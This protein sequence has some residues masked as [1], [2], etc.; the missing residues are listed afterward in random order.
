VSGNPYMDRMNAIARLRTEKLLIENQIGDEIAKAWR[1]SSNAV[2]L[3]T[4]ASNLGMLV[5]DVRQT[6]WDRGIQV[7]A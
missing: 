4:F 3:D 2:D 6:L 7:R 5:D 1:L